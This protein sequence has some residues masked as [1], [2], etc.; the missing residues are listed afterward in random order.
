MTTAFIPQETS[1]GETRIAASVDVV[2][3]LCTAGITVQ[4]EAG[5]GTSAHLSDADLRAVG[6]EVV[7]DGAAA[8]S[9]A[10][11]VLKVAP[12]SAEEAGRLKA[13]AI[14]VS[15][16]YPT[17]CPEVVEVLM[18]R[19]V[20]TLAMELIPRISRAQSMDSLSSQAT[21]AGYKAVLLGAANL[22]K[23]CPL[24]M[25]AAGTT[26]PAKVVVFGAGVAGLQAIATA[27][28]LG[29]VVE[30]TD[31]RLAV[32][33]QVESLGAKFIDVPGAEDMED[34]GGYAKE[35][36][37]D[38]LR[39]QREEV[40]KRVAE[41]DIVITTA[42][43][44]GRP[45][46]KLVSADMVR[47]MRAGSVIVDIAVE[48][49]GNCELSRCGEIINSEGVTIVGVPNLPATLPVHASELYA[50]NIYNLLK[51]FIG[52]EGALELDAE[53]EVIAGCT[54]TRGGELIHERTKALLEK[55]GATS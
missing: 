32:K 12:P 15:H 5:A 34:E 13:G 27:K 50:K 11:L 25:T 54:L 49:G 2:K 47:S 35:A 39:R 7:A 42:L 28:R 17:N 18:E 14:L 36:D 53:D 24:M 46:P 6:A 51:P 43:I 3:R 30:A 41:A 33:E 55:E 1:S 26:A 45:A 38:F 31:I 52:D 16:V 4:V 48:T 21:L 19:Q 23:L 20:T 44:P 22:G 29:C 9:A 8:W 10:D 37:E 40:A